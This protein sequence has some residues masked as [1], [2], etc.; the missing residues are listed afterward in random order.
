M[1]RT[2]PFKTINP[3]IKQLIVDE[4]EDMK[5]SFNWNEKGIATNIQQAI[6]ETRKGLDLGWEKTRMLMPRSEDHH[7]WMHFCH[8]LTVLYNRDNSPKRFSII[9]NAINF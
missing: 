7:H 4:L 3:K 2:A 1:F 8:L 6:E 5:E 9:R